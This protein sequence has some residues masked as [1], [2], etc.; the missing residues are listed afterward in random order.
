[1]LKI[2]YLTDLIA[3]PLE[4]FLN[5][6]FFKDPKQT[7]ENIRTVNSFFNLQWKSNIFIFSFTYGFFLNEVKEEASIQNTISKQYSGQVNDEKIFYV[8][9]KGQSLNQDVYLVSYMWDPIGKT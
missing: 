9:T 8:I 5:L 7:M 4:I 3:N 2:L 1:M 6:N